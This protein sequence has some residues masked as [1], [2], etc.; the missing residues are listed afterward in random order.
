[1]N[2]QEI[3]KGVSSQPHP[4]TLRSRRE[5]AKKTPVD[6]ISNNFKTGDIL[7]CQVV[8]LSKILDWLNDSTSK[9]IGFNDYIETIG[10]V[11][12]SR[13]L[14]SSDAA[15]EKLKMLMKLKTISPTF[16]DFKKLKEQWNDINK[17]VKV[18][19]FTLINVKYKTLQDAKVIP[20]FTEKFGKPLDGKN[21]VYVEG[22]Y[23]SRSD[24][25]VWSERNIKNNKFLLQ[26]KESEGLKNY[27]R[28]AVNVVLDILGLPGT[29]ENILEYINNLSIKKKSALAALEKHCESNP[30]DKGT[31]YLLIDLIIKT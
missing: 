21:G 31:V 27:S 13:L 10:D 5:A 1:M 12:Y 19:N 26:Q 4:D 11:D 8:N 2:E 22:H 25:Q 16:I 17:I 14:P 30:V 18:E 29:P 28:A 7:Y 23:V 20:A 3:L 6:I 24:W 15:E 9:F